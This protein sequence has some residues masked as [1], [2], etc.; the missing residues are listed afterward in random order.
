MGNLLSAETKEK[1]K[2][3]WPNRI[4]M[5]VAPTKEFAPKNLLEKDEVPITEEDER[6]HWIVSMGIVSQNPSLFNKIVRSIMVKLPPVEDDKRSVNNRE[7]RALARASWALEIKVAI[8][9]SR[10]MQEEEADG[11]LAEVDQ[12]LLDESIFG[13]DENPLHQLLTLAEKPTPSP[14]LL[15]PSMAKGGQGI[16]FL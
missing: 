11:F 14:P 8:A 4:M 7:E 1:V 3:R 13:Q 12:M 16:L 2:K 6:L 5:G 10:H 15:P 9:F